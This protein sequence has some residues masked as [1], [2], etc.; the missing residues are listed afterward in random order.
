[1]PKKKKEIKAGSAYVLNAAGKIL[2]GAINFSCNSV[3]KASNPS[4][5]N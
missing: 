5:A 2:F 1:M 3:F 4:D